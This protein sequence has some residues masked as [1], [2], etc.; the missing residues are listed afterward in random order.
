MSEL[1]KALTGYRHRFVRDLSRI[2]Q[3]QEAR[4]LALVNGQS[5]TAFG[6]MLG[7]SDVRSVESFQAA[8]PLHEWRDFEP[9]IERELGEGQGAFLA[10][11][12]LAVELTSG[13]SSARKM[14]PY[15]QTH[16]ASFAAAVYP[17][18]DDWLLKYPM[19]AN[20]PWFWL[21]SPS[22]QQSKQTVNG[23]PI[24]LPGGD[25]AYFGEA[26]ANPIGQRLMVPEAVSRLSDLA[27]WRRVC[28]A[29]L[30][31]TPPALLSVWSPSLLLVLL[32]VLRDESMAVLSLLDDWPYD[33][34]PKPTIDKARREALPDLVMGGPE[35]IWPEVVLVS[36]WTSASA[37]RD[38]L[39]LKQRWPSLNIQGKGLLSTEGVVSVPL[40]GLSDP[41]LAVNSGFYEFLCDDGRM[42]LAHELPA[43]CEAQV[44]MST[45]N[46]LLRYQTQ[47]YIRC[48]GHFASAPLLKFMG[49]SHV[50]SDLCGEKLHDGFVATVLSDLPCFSM[51]ISH[52]TKRGYVWV[53]D[54]LCESIESMLCQV[55]QGLR[56]N[57]H[58]AWGQDVGQLSALTVLVFPNF[59]QRLHTAVQ[60]SGR[61]IGDYKPPALAT[62]FEKKVVFDESI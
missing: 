20:T 12:V 15:T 46:G 27:Q 55:E 47:D 32:D 29:Y 18:L 60:A 3:I 21:I 28:L 6:R 40:L 17:W 58:Y 49:R 23:I 35:H 30:L 2:A 14:I 53:A 7:L 48:T 45:A 9:W 4:I 43:G 41:V 1:I 37:E 26:L 57:P 59:L 51:L 31:A 62:A 8:V 13:S 11:P 38:V 16:L 19:L 22:S 44:V 10:E 33:F 25:A 54:Q 36:C 56:E 50:V 5:D 34:L 52:P 61:R 39:L 42:R 24:G